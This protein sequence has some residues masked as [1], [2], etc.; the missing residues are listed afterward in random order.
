MNNTDSHNKFDTC[1]LCNSKKLN[2]LKGYEKDYLVKCHS[3][4]FVFSDRI[5]TTEELELFYKDYGTN[6]YLSP[7]TVKRYHEILDSF[8]PFRKNNRLLDIGCG[9]GLFLDVA[10]ERG[11]EVYG[12]EFSENLVSICESKNIKM[13]KGSITESTFSN[14]YFDIITSFE[15]LEHTNN[16]N[17]QINSIY[18]LL[19]KGGATYVTTPNFNSLLRFW[20][21]SSYIN[22]NYPEHITY[23]TKKTLNRLLIGSGLKKIQLV[24]SGLSITN[25][26]NSQGDNQEQVSEN[27]DDEKIREA[28]EQKG[29]RSLLKKI[30][31]SILNLLGIGDA[32]KAFYKKL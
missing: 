22:I 25:L 9:I 21:K 8:E 27:S 24:S 18:K 23:F 29:V 1:T 13:E 19:R 10:K 20:L 5:P 31:N 14:E 11:W 28:F 15:V 4:S 32:L 2:V 7:I 30:I 12:I 16:P 17:E 26:K 3:C 6:H